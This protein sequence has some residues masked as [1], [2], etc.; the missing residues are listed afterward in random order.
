MW[1]HEKNGLRRQEELLERAIRF[2][3][4][5]AHQLEYMQES[6]KLRFNKI[7]LE[8]TLEKRIPHDAVEVDVR[9]KAF[10]SF[11]E[12][13]ERRKWPKFYYPTDYINDL[14]GVRI[15]CH[16]LDDVYGVL[17]YLYNDRRLEIVS[18]SIQD[19]IDDPKEGYR[20]IHL[21]AYYPNDKHIS[22]RGN[23]RVIYEI[24]IRSELQDLWAKVSHNMLYKKDNEDNDEEFYDFD[25][26]DNFD[27]EENT[28]RQSIDN[29]FSVDIAQ[30]LSVQD[31]RKNRF[32][33]ALQQKRYQLSILLNLITIS[34]FIYIG[35]L[36]GDVAQ[37]ILG[38]YSKTAIIEWGNWKLS[39]LG[40]NKIFHMVERAVS[41]GIMSLYIFTNLKII[42]NLKNFTVIGSVVLT[43]VAVMSGDFIGITF[44]EFVKNPI[45]RKILY[46]VSFYGMLGFAI[47]ESCYQVLYLNIKRIFCMLALITIGV[48]GGTFLATLISTNLIHLPMQSH[49]I[50]DCI[51]YGI[52]MFC[53]LIGCRVV[54]EMK[55]IPV[56]RLS[57]LVTLGIFL[58]RITES[59]LQNNLELVIK[60]LFSTP[61]IQYYSIVRG[62]ATEAISSGLLLISIVLGISFK[63][64]K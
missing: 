62:I 28:C 25:S 46:W 22:I 54:L 41:Y 13:L 45:V 20:A 9:I 63:V 32:W 40:G 31:E 51:F 21:H 42:F 35:A 11:V 6:L 15:I 61:Y 2:R 27:I 30:K 48:M 64:R 1:L 33:D 52:I 53:L 43:T 7:V 14:V 49:I 57:I 59:F 39:F 60:S 16:F 29:K 37:N 10:E 34:S 36:L 19:Y 44:L 56:I 4:R 50:Y 17:E 55:S 38:F 24:Q 58:D 3:N 5:Y 26:D 8:Y 12:K 23:P 18:D 47:L